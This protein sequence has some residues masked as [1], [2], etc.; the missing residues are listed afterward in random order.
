MTQGKRLRRVRLCLGW[1]REELAGHLAM[2]RTRTLVA[3]ES[4]RF[5]K[6][7]GKYADWLEHEYFSCPQATARTPID[8][9]GAL[10]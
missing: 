10:S 6:V 9:T 7:A 3:L 8:A 4:G 2:R 1:T 5:G